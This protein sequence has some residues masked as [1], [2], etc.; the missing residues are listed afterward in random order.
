MLS[1]LP[2]LQDE[3]EDVSIDVESL[4][5]NIPNEETINYNTE[6]IYIHK[7]L[8]PICSKLIF[9]KL[10]IQLQNVLLNSIA[11]S[12]NKWMVAQKEDHSLLLLVTFL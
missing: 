3:K 1:S 12:S 7:K 8:T 11:D 6:Q 4:F 9:R 2:P 10:L 5:T